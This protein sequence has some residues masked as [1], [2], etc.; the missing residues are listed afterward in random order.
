MF[1]IYNSHDNCCPSPKDNSPVK[2]IQ[3]VEDMR[4]NFTSTQTEQW[5]G[6]RI[7]LMSFG[8]ALRKQSQVGLETIG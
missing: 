4:R 1:W 3:A 7:E 8:K 6:K 2:N 5:P